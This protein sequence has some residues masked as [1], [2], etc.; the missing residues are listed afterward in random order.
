MQIEERLQ[1]DLEPVEVRCARRLWRDTKPESPQ[2]NAGD[3]V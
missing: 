2:P 1:S 3:L